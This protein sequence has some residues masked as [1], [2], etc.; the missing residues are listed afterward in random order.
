MGSRCH[1]DTGSPILVIH[2][3]VSREAA[4]LI[5]S[6]FPIAIFQWLFNRLPR[7]EILY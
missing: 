7:F 1:L 6:V 4:P 3:S 5:Y 2:S